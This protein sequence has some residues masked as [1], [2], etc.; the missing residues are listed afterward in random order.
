MRVV[1]RLLITSKLTIYDRVFI[2]EL[3]IVIQ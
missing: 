2:T 3:R 1:L